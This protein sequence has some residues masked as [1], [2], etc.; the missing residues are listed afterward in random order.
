MEMVTYVVDSGMTPM[1]A[2]M[3]VGHRR[4]RAHQEVASSSP[5][6]RG[7]DC[8]APEPLDDIQRS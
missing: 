8:H 5:A 2:L 3:A 4:R 7:R 1:E 6:W